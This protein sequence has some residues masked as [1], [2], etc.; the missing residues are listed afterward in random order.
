MNAFMKY[1]ISTSRTSA[2]SGISSALP[3]PFGSWVLNACR[4][5]RMSSV[6]FGCSRPSF[7]SQ[8]EFIHSLSWYVQWKQSTHCGIP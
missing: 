1:G 6:V 7:F 3:L 5:L 8:A 4:T 2:L